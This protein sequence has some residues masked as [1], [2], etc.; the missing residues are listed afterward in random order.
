MTTLLLV[1]HGATLWT[2]EGRMQGGTDIT[3][4]DEGAADVRRLSAVV[5]A[6][7]PRSLVT[8]PLSRAVRTAAVLGD[9]LVDGPLEPVVDERWAEAGL[10]DWEGRTADAIGEPYGR[11]RRG[12]L[13]PPGG[14]SPREVEARVRPAVIAA[15]QRPG[16]VLVVTHGGVIRAALLHFA[17]LSTEHLVPVSAPSLTVLEVSPEHETGRL[18]HLNIPAQPGV[19]VPVAISVRVAT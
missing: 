16:P 6:W 4:S 2:R 7:R 17:G 12:L 19:A 9:A 11:W 13:T 3:L 10:G 18:H 15:A 1:R 5:A 14:E 8:S